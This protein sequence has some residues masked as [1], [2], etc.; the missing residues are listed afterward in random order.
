MFKKEV[1]L[2]NFVKK[3]KILNYLEYI[4]NTYKIQYKNL[5]IYNITENKDEY[6]VTFKIDSDKR[7]YLNEIKGSTILH[8]KRGCVFSI[9]ALNK[10]IEKE[11]PNNT[12]VD[13]EIMNNKLIVTNKSEI[14]IYNINK[15]EDKGVLFN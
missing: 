14:V 8:Y 1:L 11:T 15:I 5:F 3:N 12:N 6:L 9:N 4:H 7:F 2:G 10:F 13:W